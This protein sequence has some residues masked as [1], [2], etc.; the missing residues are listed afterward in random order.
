MNKRIYWGLSILITLIICISVFMLLRNTNIDTE[1]VYN[2]EVEPSKQVVESISNQQPKNNVLTQQKIPI[3]TSTDGLDDDSHN[4]DIIENDNPLTKTDFSGLDLADIKIPDNLYD[5]DMNMSDPNFTHW[6]YK[7]NKSVS[8]MMDAAK[9]SDEVGHITGK[10]FMDSIKNLTYEE[11]K[12]MAELLISRNRKFNNAVD[13]YI[14]I[15]RE[16]PTK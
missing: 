14:K 12:A 11:K 3:T 15:S 5:G 16:R 10:T 1:I 2:G 9:S 7:Y 8:N 4:T 6:M 13:E